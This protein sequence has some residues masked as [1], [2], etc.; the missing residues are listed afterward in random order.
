MDWNSKSVSEWEWEKLAGFSAKS[1]DI[2]E[3]VQPSNH[4]IEGDGRVENGSVYSSGGV[5]GFSGSDLGHGSS[6]RSS[7]SASADSSSKEGSRKYGIVDGIPKD[8]TE[9]NEWSRVDGTGNNPSLGVSVS[10]GEPIIGLKLG[11]RTYFED[12]CATSTTKTSTVSSVPTS[13]AVPSKRSRASYQSTQAP[14]CQVEGCNLD[15]KSAKDYHRRHRICES[16]S[17]S[18]K[19]I[20]A[21]MERRFC[22]QCSRF[23]ELAEF[24]DKK[25]SCRR[26]LSDHNA[27]RRRPQPEAIQFNSSRLSSSL[28]DGRQQMNLMLNRVPLSTA[29]PTWSSTCSY[30]KV[31]HAGDSITR[32]IKTCGIDRLKLQTDEMPGAPSMLQTG[33]TKMLSFESSMPRF[34]SQ[35]SAASSFAPNIDV[36]PDVRRALSLLSTNSWGLNDSEANVLDQLMH[37]N[38]SS[39]PQPVAHA[40]LQNWVL[41]SSGHEQVE[42][43]PP[44]SRVHSLNQHNNGSMRFQEFQLL[45]SPYQSGCFHS[46]HIN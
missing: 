2:P 1:I 16:H 36:A 33:S 4:E 23:H 17:K 10:S 6:S 3:L 38:E 28:Y 37:V 32:P 30:S 27:R 41:P 29:N 13:L 18:P 24:D 26:R 12:L 31:T 22:Q 43:P 9:K 21:G 40:E 20:V 35:G 11:R 19:V 5:G 25:R 34:L 7:I 8:L 42:Q 15:L 46:N 39:M 44:E 45:K 14:S